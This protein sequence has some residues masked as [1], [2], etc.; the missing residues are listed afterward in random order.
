M[1]WLSLFVISII[2]VQHFGMPFDFFD[3]LRTQLSQDETNSCRWPCHKKGP[4]DEWMRKQFF[5]DKGL[6]L[7]PDHQYKPLSYPNLQ[8]LVPPEFSKFKP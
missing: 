6:P 8:P 5:D 1:R 2:L 4:E 7:K 3:F